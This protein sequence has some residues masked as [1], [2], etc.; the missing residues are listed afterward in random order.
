MLGG[1]RTSVLVP[2]RAPQGVRGVCTDTTS[3][4]TSLPT[5]KLNSVFA[6][7]LSFRNRVPHQT[8]GD[9]NEAFCLLWDCCESR[10]CI[11]TCLRSIVCRLFSA[12]SPLALAFPAPAH[13]LHR[14]G[15][16]YFSVPCCRGLPGR[17]HSPPP[18]TH[19]HS[20][21]HYNIAPPFE[22]HTITGNT[23]G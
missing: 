2:S 11:I 22:H 13:V 10:N 7:R 8:S 14:S 17:P 18:L 16:P 23:F 5:G 19:T 4:S 9:Q 6:C 21:S 12:C 15:M 20:F 1:R 3:G